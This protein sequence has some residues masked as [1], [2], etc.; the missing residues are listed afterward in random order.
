MDDAA[1]FR[2]IFEATFSRVRRYVHHCGVTG[3]RADDIVAETYLVAWRRLHDVPA[4]D[5]LPWLLVVA[6]NLWLNQRRGDRR[7]L[8]MVRRLPVPAP[9]PPPGEPGELAPIRQALASLRPAEQEVLRL[10]A[11]D[12][13]TPEQASTVLGCSPGAFR[14]RLHRARRRLAGELAKRS[15]GSGQIRGETDPVREVTDDR[16]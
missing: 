11:W 16:A 5:P 8:A 1:R 3:G 14:V 13:L 10:V 12:D 4:D 6:R 15:N 2:A 7:H 9:V